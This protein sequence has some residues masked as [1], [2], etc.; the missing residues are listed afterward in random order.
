MRK[1]IGYFY[2]I[3]YDM[4]NENLLIKLA[5]RHVEGIEYFAIRPGGY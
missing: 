2:E 3:A 4:S 5:L 1:I